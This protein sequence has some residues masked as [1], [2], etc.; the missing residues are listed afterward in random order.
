MISQKNSF[1]VLIKFSALMW[2]I[3][4]SAQA[5]ETIS[6]KKSV[7]AKRLVGELSIDGK[8]TEAAW[9]DVPEA[10]DFIQVAPQTGSPTN[11]PTRVK[12]LYDQRNIYIGIICEDSDGKEAIR[13]TDLSRDFAAA[14]SDYVSVILD[15]FNDHR[16]A[17][18]LG[19]NAYGAQVD[20]ISFDAQF[21]DINWS[22]L[23]KVR[24]SFIEHGWT[25]EFE[26]PIT[27]LQYRL[28]TD[29]LQ[30]IAI[31][32][33]RVRR[34]S[35]EWSVWSPIP[36]NF[37]IARMEYAGELTNLVLP[38][39]SSNIRLNPYTLY[40]FNRKPVQ[41]GARK[42]FN[43]IKVGG[44]LRWGITPNTVADFTLNT[45]FAQ[46]EADA[47]V[48]NTSRFSVLFPEK[49]QFFLEN[50]SLFGAGLTADN[51]SAGNIQI[52]P[53]FSRTIGLDASGTPL[54]IEGGI[55]TIHRSARRNWGAMAVRQGNEGTDDSPQGSSPTTHFFVGRYSENVGKQNRIG[56]LVTLK[57]AG[58]SQAQSSY[59]NPTAA[60]DG[61]FRFGNAH[62]L[63]S[64]VIYATNSGTKRE[65]MA[66][67][68]QYLFTTNTVKAWLTETYIGKDY[69]SEM[70]FVSRSNVLATIGGFSLD[71]RKGWVPV[72]KYTLSFQPGASTEWYHQASDQL[73]VERRFI[74]T[75]FLLK[76]ISGGT[77]SVSLEPTQQHLLKPFKPLGIVITEGKYN[78]WRYKLQAS[79]DASKKIS[80][81]LKYETGRY[82]NGK[83]DATNITL[84]F[85]PVPYASVKLSAS[86]N[87]FADVG[88][89]KV[90]SS[91]SIYSVAG[92][93]ALNP[94]LQLAV[95]YQ[96][97][98]QQKLNSVNARF[99][100]EY[101][102]LS[103]I[104]LVW[105]SR[106]YDKLESQ[107]EQAAIF[108]INFVK[109]F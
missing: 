58:P 31:N 46:A 33:E 48:N 91:V 103:F 24:T 18:Y 101:R 32:F 35:N 15:G 6:P 85:A 78:Y 17:M 87:D 72:K 68:A 20:F 53:F 71:I 37:R 41:S 100:W 105:N 67:F 54:P 90:S 73:L 12:L 38:K 70:G 23:W 108:K 86:R 56:G 94:R 89:D 11:F 44:E 25:A 16:N 99:S 4:Q 102:P 30:H 52:I 93:F 107:N 1:R 57:K 82:Y 5:Q 2:M 66:A 21:T 98:T 95:L 83:L 88:E 29:S 84:K 45:D 19:T 14:S 50:A 51:T 69:S 104:Y 65:G 97:S 10:T 106:A 28:S 49:R 8:L 96:R 63:N 79:S 42:E 61:F 76:L 36:R 80:Y 40:S 62:S 43:K 77:V 27:T 3:W 26:V 92:N 75:P 13:S 9:S 59:N 74:L 60:I 81:T 109:Q 47:F 64:M 55:R 22:G 39:P 34:K 7:E